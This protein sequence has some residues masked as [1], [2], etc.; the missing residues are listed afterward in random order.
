MP[1]APP[2]KDRSTGLA[3]GAGVLIVLC[4]VGHALL[5]GVGVAGLASAAG[6]ATG[7]IPVVAGIALLG[8]G[9]IVLMRRRNRNRACSPT[10]SRRAPCSSVAP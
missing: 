4:C 9:A 5:L 10:D 8:L 1:E 2:P 3:I 6:A 7:S